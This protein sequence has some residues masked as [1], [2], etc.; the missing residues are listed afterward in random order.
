MFEDKHSLLFLCRF[1][2]L[3]LKSESVRVHFINKLVKNIQEMLQKR[4]IKAKLIRARARVFVETSDKQAVE[5]LT[6]TF[7][8]SSISEVEKMELDSYIVKKNVFDFVNQK[9]KKK[10]PTFAVRVKRE[11]KHDFTSQEFASRLGA[12]IVEKFKLKVNLSKPGLLVE[13]E[14]RDK[15]AYLIKNRVNCPGGLPLGTGGT[16]ISMVSSKNGALSSYLLMKRGCKVIPILLDGNNEIR[17]L[18]D[19]DSSL[20]IINKKCKN[21]NFES[22]Q[23]IAVRQAKRLKTK[24]I[25]YEYT[26]KQ[27]KQ[28]NF[29]KLDNEFISFFPLVGFNDK[30]IKSILKAI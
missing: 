7:G 25:I 9:I 13:I 8:L 5:V 27:S 17:K 19:Y 14:I 26:L 22:I 1:D 29:D 3:W 23:K 18:E 2:E 20:K 10:K 21:I 12:E 28:L 16:L 6:K 24:G 30:E 11:G 15:E 4:K